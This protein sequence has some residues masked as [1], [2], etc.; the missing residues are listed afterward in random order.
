M[1]TSRINTYVLVLCMAYAVSRYNVFSDV[2]W[3]SLPLYVTNKAVSYAG[4]IF[5]GLSLVTR[6]GA[7]RKTWGQTGAVCIGGHIPMSL[8]ILN[9]HYFAEF[10]VSPG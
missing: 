4:L 2:P 8:M 1:T 10:Y 3:S 6:D 5:L 9:P 7:R